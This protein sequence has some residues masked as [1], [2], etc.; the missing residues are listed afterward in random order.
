MENQ[1]TPDKTEALVEGQE[2]PKKDDVVVSGPI[3]EFFQT[4]NSL[5]RIM[6][7]ENRMLLEHQ[8]KDIKDIQLE[9]TQLS[10]KYEKELRYLRQN[11]GILGSKGSSIREKI[12]EKVAVFQEEIMT[13]GRIILRFK[14]LSEGL[15]QEIGKEAV[16]QKGQV[17][18]YCPSASMVAPGAKPIPIAL[19]QVI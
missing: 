9:K 12:K 15:V 13:H 1:V 19:N 16:K 8:L 5:S 7:Q 10:G 6:K 14:N 3:A 18:N 11:P 17:S 4:I 2:A